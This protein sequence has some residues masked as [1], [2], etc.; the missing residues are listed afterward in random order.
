MTKPK[1]KVK[2]PSL[3]PPF[4]RI[5]WWVSVLLAITSYC[6]LKYLAPQLQFTSQ[7]LQNL[8]IAAPKLAPMAAIV[9]LLLAAIR[10]YDTDDEKLPE[11]TDDHKT[12]T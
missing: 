12:D 11:D 7:T 10:L 2:S 3:I 8:A 4:L 6:G 1:H 9:F 5:S